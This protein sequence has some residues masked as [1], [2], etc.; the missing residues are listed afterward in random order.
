MEKVEKNK[1]GKSDKILS[2]NNRKW[3]LK[4][5]I[6]INNNFSFDKSLLLSTLKNVN[7][8]KTKKII[9]GTFNARR[10]ISKK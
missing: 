3:G 10:L 5:K 2:W 9:L 4:A 8:N 6:A 7:R 1:K